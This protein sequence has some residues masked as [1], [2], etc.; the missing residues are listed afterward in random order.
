MASR[1]TIVLAAAL[2]AAGCGDRPD[3]PPAEERADLADQ[4]IM[5]FSTTETFG[6]DKSWRLLAAKAEVFGG[7]G[8]SK[9]YGV[10]VLFYGPEGDVTSTLTSERGRVSEGTRDLQAF[11]NVLLESSDGVTLETNSLRWDNRNERIWSAEFVTVTE[12]NKVLTGYGFDSDPDLKNV[13]VHSE[14]NITIREGTPDEGADNAETAGRI[15]G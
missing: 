1:V 12:G 3:P 9:V 4:V 15:G 2:F 11:G 8:F 10:K 14:V 5:E 6:G 7:K 13:Q